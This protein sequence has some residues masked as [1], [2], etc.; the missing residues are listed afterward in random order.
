M[1][2][3]L[4]LLAI[5]GAGL[6]ARWSASPDRLVRVAMSRRRSAIAACRDGDLVKIVGTVRVS[7]E[8]LVAPLSGR[9][10]AHFS[11]TCIAETEFAFVVSESRSQDFHVVDE[12][13]EALVLVSGAQV[14][15]RAVRR[16]H[17]RVGADQ[18]GRLAAFLE[19]HNR[20]PLGNQIIRCEEAAL[21]AGALVAVVG[22]ARSVP[23]LRAASIYRD[24]ARRLE[25]VRD[26]TVGLL[27]TDRERALS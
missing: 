11:T 8:P 10:C 6:L 26:A 3:L 2:E 19:R 13:G 15:L 20:R 7:R 21:E 4:I 17:D 5:T 24:V 16:A 25:I 9:T 1:G 23:D 12:T 14:V 27:V 22:R 18:A